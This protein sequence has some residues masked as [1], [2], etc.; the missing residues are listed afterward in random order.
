MFV[1][2]PTVYDFIHIGNA[3]TFVFFDFLA[4]YLRYKSYE[5]DYLQNITDI[6]DKI[7]IRAENEGSSWTHVAKKFEAE[8]LDDAAKLGITS[9]RYAKA[10]D[11]IAEIIG[12]IETLSEKGHTYSIENDGIYF[13]LKTFPEYGKLS[14]RTAE[15]AEDATSRIDESAN[16]K[17]RGDFVL[18]KFSK[19][20]EPAWDSPFGSGR[21]GWHIED[22]AITEK[23]FG[24]QY[25]L[26][27]GGQDLMFPHH[28]A[29]IS[30]QESAS[31]L[32]PF[33]KYWLHAG[34][35]TSKSDKMSKSV[36]NFTTAREVLEKF[37]TE[38]LRFFFLSGHYRSPLEF[39]EKYLLQAKAATSRISDFIEK[40]N[41]VSGEENQKIT[42]AFGNL[43]QTFFEALDDDLNTPSAFGSVFD[44]I[45]TTNPA[46]M[47]NEISRS[48]AEAILNFF[49]IINQ[50]LDIIPATGESVPAEILELIEK[51]DQLR[52]DQRWPEAD[53]IRDEIQAQGYK[54]E[55]T[56]FGTFAIHN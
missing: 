10:T 27:G 19:P 4:K 20:G 6:D 56:Q 9:P 18:W 55:D 24:S 3:R 14:G 17:N 50:I 33:V 23:N 1:C 21:P 53:A 38:I 8:F 40:L 46:L 36:G 5:V 29:E 37:Q 43:N 16:K 15:M 2:G 48:Q 42:D 45:R 54:L 39:D 35:L 47:N 28:E 7:I 25:D 12:Q 11:H 22:T 31:G 52:K 30:Q 41:R 51:R 13:D 44:F 34:F 26:H 49:D 32:K